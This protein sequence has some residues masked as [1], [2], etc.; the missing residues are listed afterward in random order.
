M[1]FEAQRKSRQP[2]AAAA[3][4]SFRIR[5]PQ[6]RSHR[7]IDDSRF[8]DGDVNVKLFISCA[9]ACTAIRGARHTYSHGRSSLCAGPANFGTAHPAE[10]LPQ[11]GGLRFPRYRHQ[12]PGL[13]RSLPHPAARHRGLAA[14][15]VL[16]SH[17]ACCHPGCLHSEHPAARLSHLSASGCGSGASGTW[18]RV[19][20]HTVCNRHRRLADHPR[21]RPICQR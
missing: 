18:I 7:C 17:A 3:D 15:V 16:P 19:A 1:D 8:N 11:L 10:P 21:Q 4:R 20:L 2:F 12:H 13:C 9:S 14:P 6:S 5:G